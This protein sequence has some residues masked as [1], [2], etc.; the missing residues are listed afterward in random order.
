MP[1]RFITA[2]SAWG[3]VLTHA[4]TI[5]AQS[6]ITP[7]QSRVV[8]I[9]GVL[10]P[11]DGQPLGAFE[12]I[13]LAIYAD[14]SGGSPLWHETQ[15]VETDAAGRY[16]AL[17]GA[18]QSDGVPV[19]VFASGEARWIGVTLVRPGELEGARR[20]LTSVP[21]AVHA[22]NAETLGGRPAS[23]YM[24]S[25]AASRNA[26]AGLQSSTAGIEGDAAP[27]AVLTGTTNY[28]AKYVSSIDVGN[29]ALYESDGR[30]GVGTTTPLDL[31][32]IRFADATGAFTGLA[33]QNLGGTATSY[34]GMLFYDQLGQLAQFQ[35]FNNATHEYRINNIARNGASVLDGSINFL[36]GSTSRFKIATNG[37]VG[38]GTVNPAAKL[39][40]AGNAVVNGNVTAAD[41]NYL[42]PQTAYYAVNDAAF[43]SREGG[44]VGKSNGNGGAYPTTSTAWGLTAAL[45]LPD[46]ATITNVRF[47]YVDNSPSNVVL[48]LSAHNMAGGFYITIATHSSAVESPAVQTVDV[49]PASAWTVD[50]S[51]HSLNVI[52]FPLGAW[53]NSLMMVRGV[54]VTYTMPRAAR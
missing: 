42:K 15:S 25:S 49:P 18:T 54:I 1:I 47:I 7:N 35:G 44:G 4:S 48:T 36:I 22:S 27:L 21:Y 31:M 53:S 28:L 46:G 11:A 24:L 12:L 50:N 8:S 2:L 52:A 19:D 13:V 30:V 29:S 41:F 26:A 9:S 16:T 45:N 23:A 6:T 20:R 5:A 34:S 39:D 33:V 43:S 51:T 14:E 3:L 32:H 10:R 38:I 17:L 40:V 37:N